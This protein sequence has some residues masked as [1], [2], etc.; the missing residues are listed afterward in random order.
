MKKLV[1]QALAFIA[2][3]DHKPPELRTHSEHEQYLRAHELVSLYAQKVVRLY[4][5]R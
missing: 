3:Y 2:Y 5:Y 4:A 1:L